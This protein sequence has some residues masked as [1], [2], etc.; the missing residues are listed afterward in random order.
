M[1][2]LYLLGGP[3]RTAKTSIMSALMVEKHTTFIPADA[4][5]EGLRNVFT[6]LPHQMLR[7]IELSGS[8]E[9]KTSI[10]KGGARKSFTN[11]GTEAELSLQAILGMLD[12]YG[13][14]NTS[15]AFEGAAIT[16]D[17]VSGLRITGFNVRAAFVGYT[18]ASHADA[19][20]S[21]AKQ[22]PEDWINQWLKGEDGD[23]TKIRAWVSEQA[24][25][26]VSLQQRAEALK[27]PFF[28]ISTQPYPSYVSA[29]QSYYCDLS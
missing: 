2:T 26:C 1:N 23:E 12:Y 7:N 8:A 25:K 27:Y 22:N 29:V 20:I 24:V 16:P 6:G 4:I 10:T 5:A 19:I 13:N 18:Q 21:Y 28:D 15:V 11:K 14:N 9:H 3:P 17:W